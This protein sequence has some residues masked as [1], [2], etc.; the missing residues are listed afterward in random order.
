VRLDIHIF[1]DHSLSLEP[2]E[3]V[4]FSRLLNLLN[5]GKCDLI[6]LVWLQHPFQATIHAS[7]ALDSLRR[8]QKVIQILTHLQIET[9]SL[10]TWVLLLAKKLS[11]LDVFLSPSF[12]SE[13]AIYLSVDWVFRV[14]HYHMVSRHNLHRILALIMQSYN[15][16][17]WQNDLISLFEHG[18][19]LL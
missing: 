7:K 6:V 1:G 18:D 19:L 2:L 11:L 13:I 9:R 12:D 10:P 16:R 4:T 17:G 14:I 5:E 8:A 3:Q 15:S